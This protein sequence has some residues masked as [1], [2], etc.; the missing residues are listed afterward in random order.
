MHYARPTFPGLKSIKNFGPPT[1]RFGP[2]TL[3]ALALA[4]GQH[5]AV[6]CKE[7]SS[8]FYFEI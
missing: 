3:N 1:S 6:L 7:V 2:S 8:I 4:L 5:S